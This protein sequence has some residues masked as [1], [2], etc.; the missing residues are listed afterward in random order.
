MKWIIIDW[1]STSFRAYLLN[2]DAQMLDKK[3]S[4]DG[5][6]AFEGKGFEAFLQH[7]CAD[8]LASGN[9]SVLMAG[10]IG[11]RNG[12]VEAPY[13]TTPTKFNELA[14]GLITV[15]NALGLDIW[16]VPGIS[17]NQRD[18]MRGEELQIFGALAQLNLTDGMICLPGTHSKWARVDDLA[19]S[20]FDTFMTGEMFA[21]LGEHSSLSGLLSVADFDHHSFIAGLDS[22]REPAGLL[23][24][25]F[26]IRGRVLT[27]SLAEKNAYSLLS[28][29]LIGSEFIG[30]EFIGSQHLGQS[31]QA[32]EVIF[33]GDPELSRL[34]VIAAE[35]FGIHSQQMSAETAV[36]SGFS[37]IIHY[38]SVNRKIRC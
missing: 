10:M 30:S 37:Q 21:L 4:K 3:T 36:I 8:W 33:V 18:V 2:Q 15:D 26:A 24:Q 29:L 7:T 6:F 27:G 17:H 14:D 5:V 9:V 35:H 32:G 16:L 13:L 20:H 34:Y 11:S 31:G 38:L 1:G 25:L 22:A 12:W 23:N 28:G 19:I